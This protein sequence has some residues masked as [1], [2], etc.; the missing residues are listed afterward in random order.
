M[1]GRSLISQS[2][3][4]LSASGVVVYKPLSQCMRGTLWT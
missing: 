3:M 2:L 1:I 4:P